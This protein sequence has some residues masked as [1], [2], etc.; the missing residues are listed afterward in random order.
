MPLKE[1]AAG[2]GDAKLGVGTSSHRLMMTLVAMMS[3]AAVDLSANDSPLQD[4]AMA[5]ESRG[6]AVSQ[7]LNL[8][9]Q[10]QKLLASLSSALERRVKHSDERYQKVQRKVRDLK[11]RATIALEDG[12]LTLADQLLS[13]AIAQ[14]SRLTR[15]VRLGPGDDA[16]LKQRYRAL[17]QNLTAFRDSLAATAQERNLDA[18][19]TD[20]ERIDAL[21]KA[22]ADAAAENRFDR[23]NRLLASAYQIT[24]ANITRLRA[25]ETIYHKLEFNSP[26]DEY[27]YEQQR[28]LSHELLLGMMVSEMA[29]DDV[30]R[31]HIDMLVNSAAKLHERARQLWRAQQQRDA[32]GTEGEAVLE[33]VTALRLAGLHIPM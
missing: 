25:N 10:K 19:E 26:D 28:Y 31:H 14:V 12:E 30:R 32:I 27:R 9:L 13:E 18:G 22:A 7:S 5:E 3:G 23:A 17:T 6:E 1:K 21:T 2:R 16:E 24:V 8:L 11:V 15:S 33:L 20:I 29:F 4:K